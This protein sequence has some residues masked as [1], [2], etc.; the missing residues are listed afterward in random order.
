MGKPQIRALFWIL[1]EEFDLDQ[2]TKMMGILPTRQA[3]RKEIYCEDGQAHETYWELQ[4]EKMDSWDVNDCL[5][6]LEQQLFPLKSTIQEINRQYGTATKVLICI[7][8]S[9]GDF[10]AMQL[11]HATL[12]FISDV[13]GTCE[14]DIFDKDRGTEDKGTVLLSG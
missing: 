11:E 12:Q 7:D 4:T 1:A 13:Q 8:I 10:P 9:D 3:F 2:V 5:Q 6:I 14:F